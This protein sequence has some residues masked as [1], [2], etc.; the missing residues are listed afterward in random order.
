MHEIWTENVRRTLY[1]RLV[2]LFGPLDNW[3]KTSSPGGDQ[4]QKYDEFC[5][6]YW[7]ALEFLPDR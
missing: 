4:D 6:T 2:E 5:E 7:L 3:K 1:E